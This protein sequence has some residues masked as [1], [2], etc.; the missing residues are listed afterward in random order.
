[1]MDNR[2]NLQN[3]G[4]DEMSGKIKQRI[5]QLVTAKSKGIHALVHASHAL[6]VLKGINVSKFDQNSEDDPVILAQL[7]KVAQEWGIQ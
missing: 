2:S 6:L 4:E 1:M 3:N 7:D 5:D